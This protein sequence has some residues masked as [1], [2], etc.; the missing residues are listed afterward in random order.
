M[1]GDDASEDDDYYAKAQQCAASQQQEQN[2]FDRYYNSLI[3]MNENET[4]LSW[5][6]WNG[7]NYRDRAAVPLTGA[8]VNVSSANRVGC[9][10]DMK[11]I[12]CG[13]NQRNYIV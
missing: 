8:G 9:L 10:M 3:I 11:Q 4:A 13:N 7:P 1:V 6:K 12:E 2:Q 5:W